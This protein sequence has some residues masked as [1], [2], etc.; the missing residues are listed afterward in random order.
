[1]E[2]KVKVIIGFFVC[3]I[4]IGL[5]FGLAFGVDWSN[6]N[7]TTE[8]PTVTS[9]TIEGIAANFLKTQDSNIGTDYYKFVPTMKN[10]DTPIAY[11]NFLD[12]IRNNQNFLND[13]VEV[14]KSGTN[15]DQ[16]FFECTPVK[17]STLETQGFEFVLKKTDKLANRNPDY[18]VFESNLENCQGGSTDFTYGLNN[19]STLICPCV[20]ENVNDQ[21]KYT[22]LAIF[23]K[24]AAKAD[25]D[26]VIKKAASVM[27]DKVTQSN[28]AAQNWFLSTD[29]SGGA[30]WLHVRISERAKYYTF[31]DY[32]YAD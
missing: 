29:G 25:V 21:S 3:A 9:E 30:A 31:D 11:K 13:F 18:A 14:L 7:V 24:E 2:G 1:M 12:M 27:T 26:S 20:P 5:G 10:G 19:D 28:D 22:H 4:A 17:K 6:N 23:V 15:F 16:Y 8:K 32:R